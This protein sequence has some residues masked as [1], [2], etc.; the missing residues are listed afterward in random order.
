M[1]FPIVAYYRVSTTRQ[2]RSGLG[3]EAQ[4][5]IVREF[6]LE[7]GRPIVAEFTEVQSGTVRKLEKRA[8]LRAALDTAR[9][10]GA[11]L[12][13]AKLDRLARDAAFVLGLRASGVDFIAC[14]FPA[15]NRLLI[16]IIAAVAEYEAGLI[17]QRTRDALAAAKARGQQL[18]GRRAGAGGPQ[19][20]E[21]MRVALAAKQ[22]ARRDAVMPMVK[23]AYALE[24]DFDDAARA[25][26]RSGTPTLTRKGRWHGTTVRRLIEGA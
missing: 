1:S 16:T 4:Q 8:E 23:A 11:T 2:G 26:N 18:G 19:Q 17:A 10:H 25:L 13:V 6:A 3:L 7:Q 21:R 20:A 5:R 24:A 12:V 14:D 15:A 22:Q 9:K